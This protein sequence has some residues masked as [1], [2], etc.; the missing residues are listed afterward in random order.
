MSWRHLDGPIRTVTVKNTAVALSAHDVV[1]YDGSG[2]VEAISA[3]QYPDGV[4]HDDG[5]AAGEDYLKM[6]LLIPYSIW[7]VTVSSQ[8]LVRGVL[9]AMAGASNV[10]GG[11]GDDPVVGVVVNKDIASGDTTGQI[12]ILPEGQT[13]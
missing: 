12:M 8:T 10:D 2:T 11:D 6:D 3:N 4:M 7:E 1:Q 13:V 9:V 5:V